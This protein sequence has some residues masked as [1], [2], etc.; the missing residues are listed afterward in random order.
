MSD[1]ARGL[2][3][4]CCGDPDGARPDARGYFYDGQPLV[5]GC[6]GQVMLDAETPPSI[7]ASD[8]PCG[9]EEAKDEK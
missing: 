5:C 3:C 8:C 2:E 7:D 4:P 9:D 6:A 1:E